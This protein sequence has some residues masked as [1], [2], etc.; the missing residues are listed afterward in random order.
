M[1]MVWRAARRAALVFSH[2]PLVRPADRALGVAMWV[3]TVVA[4]A[5]VPFAAATGSVVH[6]RM[7][8][9]AAVEQQDRHVTAA[10]LLADAPTAVDFTGSA[11]KD[12]SAPAS[13]RGPDGR[14]HTATISVTSGMHTGD[15][16]PIW[17]DRDGEVVGAPRT[18][19]SAA[20]DGFGVAFLILSGTGLAL[21][22]CYLLLRTALRRR[23]HREW[24]L[25]WHEIEPR[26]SGRIGREPA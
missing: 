20:M 3:G 17:V 11:V 14:A 18:A 10:T 4:M 5:V 8:E 2:N 6:A 21:A 13:W 12:S 16:T 7:I 24:E 19:E 23:A 25:R 1:G 15:S 26:W 9:S 22:G